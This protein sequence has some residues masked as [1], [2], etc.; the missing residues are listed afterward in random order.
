MKSVFIKISTFLMALL[1]LL[2]TFSLTIEKHF[3]GD[4]LV[5]VSYFGNTQGCAEEPGED[6]CDTP[7]VIEKKNCCKDEIE[8]I[9]GQEDL[10]AVTKKITIEKQ[11]FIVAFIHTYNNLFI[12]LKKQI[13]LHKNYCPP[14]L[15]SD[16]QVLHEVFII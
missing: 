5:D 11:Q 1:V 12:D 7:E 8:Q 13:V 2:S 6:D 3:C 10:Q 16:I 4:S 9:K 14:N 15:V